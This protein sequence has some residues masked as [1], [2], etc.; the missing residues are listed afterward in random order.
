M[1][2][3]IIIGSGPAGN[4]GR[5]CLNPLL[6]ASRRRELVKTTGDVHEALSVILRPVLPTANS[7]SLTR[8]D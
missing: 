2:Q 7:A 1:R 6:I 4:T 3:T 8:S 5:A